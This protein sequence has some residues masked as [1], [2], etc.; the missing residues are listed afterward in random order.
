MRREPSGK[1]PQEDRKKFTP[2]PHSGPGLS[3]EN[4]GS[5]FQGAI[6]W[7]Q[8]TG[9]PAPQPR[10]CATQCLPLALSRILCSH[11]TESQFK[12]AFKQEKTFIGSYNSKSQKQSDLRCGWIKVF[13]RSHQ[14]SVS[15][16]R[17]PALLSSMS[18]LFS[19]RQAFSKW[20]ALKSTR[21]QPTSLVATVETQRLYSFQFHPSLRRKPHWC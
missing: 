18:A 4:A 3:G 20:R 7:A 8:T 19:D 14:D 9:A 10:D 13:K 1:G 15:F 17:D 2:H 5:P 6:S 12:V 16:V 21:L 11:V